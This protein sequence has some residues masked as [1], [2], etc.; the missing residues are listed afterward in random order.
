M[1]AAGGR[2]AVLVFDQSSGRRA[3]QRGRRRTELVRVELARMLQ[4]GVL[5]WRDVRRLIEGLVVQ[6]AAEDPHA[7]VTVL[8]GVDD[9][10][11]P[12]LVPV[13]VDAGDPDARVQVAQ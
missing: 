13:L 4:V 12:E 10:L 2:A 5:F 9:V 3:R 11:V 8:V 1:V 6:D 7:V